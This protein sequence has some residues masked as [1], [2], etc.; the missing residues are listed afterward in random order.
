MI[1]LIAEDDELIRKTLE[2][3]LVKENHQVISAVDGR[4][5][6]EKV[7]ETLPDLVITDIMMPYASGL[8][9]VAAVRAIEEK[10][11]PIIILSGL[12]QEEVVLD[13]FKLGADDFI[14]KPFSPSELILRI[15]RFTVGL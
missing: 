15:K 7:K 8:E 10:I 13:A 1:I 6:L 4:D 12:G 11:I 14:V 9:I 3:R 5:A 2:F